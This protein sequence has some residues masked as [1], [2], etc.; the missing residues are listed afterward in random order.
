M[1]TI[2]DGPMACS[3]T[4]MVA[5]THELKNLRSACIRYLEEHEKAYPDQIWSEEDGEGR[6][7]TSDKDKAR[8]KLV[9]KVPFQDGKPVFP[10]ANTRLSDEL[11]YLA[12]KFLKLKDRARDYPYD[13]LSNGDI[14]PGRVPSGVGPIVFAHGLPFFPVFKGYYILCGRKHV[15]WVGW[16]LHDKEYRLIKGYPIWTIG[17]VVAPGSAVALER[18][19]ERQLRVHK[20]MSMRDVAKCE[21]AAAST[22][23]VVSSFHNHGSVVPKTSAGGFIIA[24]L[25]QVP[26]YSVHCGPNFDTGGKA[27]SVSREFFKENRIEELDRKSVV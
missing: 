1:P 19:V 17:P 7:P 23:D 9:T 21:E 22:R 13:F 20:A 12:T 4:S 26:G 16:M 18:T 25:Y 15:S 10:P 2:K 3:K 6:A 8:L 11:V 24:A 5:Y 14:D 27:E